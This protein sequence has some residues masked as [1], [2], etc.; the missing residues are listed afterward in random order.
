MATYEQRATAHS[1]GR[2]H[3]SPTAG[4]AWG[5]H[6]GPC[7]LRFCY[8]IRLDVCVR[9]ILG[10]ERTS[11]TGMSNQKRPVVGTRGGPLGGGGVGPESTFSH[12]PVLGP[13][14][15]VILR[16]REIGLLPSK[17]GSPVGFTSPAAVFCPVWSRRWAGE[18]KLFPPSL[19]SPLLCCQ[20]CVFTEYLLI[21]WK[22]PSLSPPLP[23]TALGKVSSEEVR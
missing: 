20:R 22:L 8:F 5:P 1:A 10:P 4:H 14:L 7:C 13:A 9:G 21:L 17:N 3:Q 19:H 11:V 15:L 16:A 6:K 23:P 18:S 12:S 2:G